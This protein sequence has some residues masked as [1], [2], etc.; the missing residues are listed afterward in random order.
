MSDHQPPERPP[1]PD[2]AEQVTEG[3]NEAERYNTATAAI[4]TTPPGLPL[5]IDIDP[6]DYDWSQRERWRR[7]W[8]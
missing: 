6:D 7:S 1:H 8:R 4:F 3:L 2:L 5:A